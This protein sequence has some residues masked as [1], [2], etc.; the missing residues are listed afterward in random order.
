MAIDIYAIVRSLRVKFSKIVIV[1]ILPEE[2]QE[3][4]KGNVKLVKSICI[5]LKKKRKNK[6]EICK[7]QVI[8]K[9]IL[10]TILKVKK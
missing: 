4:G 3:G 8:L 2:K 7:S 10:Y 6:G 1:M 9:S 5:E